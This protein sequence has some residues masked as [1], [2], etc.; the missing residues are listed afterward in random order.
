MSSPFTLPPPHHPPYFLAST[1][2]PPSLNPQQ[3]SSHGL[4]FSPLRLPLRV[5]LRV[6]HFLAS[7]ASPS[8]P[9]S[10]TAPLTSSSSLGVRL[11]PQHRVCCRCAVMRHNAFV[12]SPPLP[13]PVLHLQVVSVAPFLR[14]RATNPSRSCFCNNLSMHEQ[15]CAG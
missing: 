14:V 9:S 10:A 7:G 5:H 11:V 12:L 2:H 3:A 1:T 4:R 8:P 6:F 13:S 15:G